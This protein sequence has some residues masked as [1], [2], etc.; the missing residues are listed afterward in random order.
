MS[1]LAVMPD[2]FYRDCK[3]C[4]RT[5]QPMV[6]VQ[7]VRDS[8]RVGQTFWVAAK[9]MPLVFAEYHRHIGPVKFPGHYYWV[10]FA[11]A[12]LAVLHKGA[13]SEECQ[14]AFLKAHS[15]AADM[16][17]MFELLGES[18]FTPQSP[19]IYDDIPAIRQ[20]MGR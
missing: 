2:P 1:Q 7:L 20:R 9:Y 6:E 3:H 17:E 16:L 10:G 11:W 13:C 14:T 15:D 5:Y 4:K 19:N 12:N 18:R 8:G